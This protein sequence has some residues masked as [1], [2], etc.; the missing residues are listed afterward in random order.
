MKG[1]ILEHFLCS[2]AP[3]GGIAVQNCVAVDV[4]VGGHVVG[5]DG[6]QQN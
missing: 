2:C 1:W 3:C 4:D 5:G 6:G